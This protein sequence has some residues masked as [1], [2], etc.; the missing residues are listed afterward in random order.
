MHIFLASNCAKKMLVEK[1]A[2][3]A[4]GDGQGDGQFIALYWD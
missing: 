1:R 4:Q 3:C 2:G